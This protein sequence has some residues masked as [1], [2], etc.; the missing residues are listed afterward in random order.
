MVDCAKEY[1]S[2]GNLSKK[3]IPPFKLCNVEG[4]H[5]VLKVT[6]IV[7]F[8]KWAESTVSI[9]AF[10][11]VVEIFSMFRV[12]YRRFGGDKNYYMPS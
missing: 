7:L 1:C 6:A 3:I 9:C 8:Q 11:M 10:F 4:H 12:K 2:Q 5:E